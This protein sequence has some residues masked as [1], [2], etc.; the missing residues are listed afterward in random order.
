MRLNSYRLDATRNRQRLARGLGWFSVGLGLAELLMPRTMCRVIGVRPHKGLMRLLGLRE[1]ASGIGIL[2]QRNTASWLQSRV[3]GDVMDLALLGNAF[4]SKHSHAGRL[5]FATAAVSG[6]TALDALCAK[7]FSDRAGMQP[8]QPDQSGVVQFRRSI[9][10]NRSPEELYGL[11]HDF[12]QLPRF[13]HHV[14]S[15]HSGGDGRWHW[16]VAGPGGLRM[17]WDAEVTEDRPNEFIAWRSLPNADLDHAGSV[18]FERARGNRGTIIRLEL[19]YRPPAGKAGALMAKVLGQS[20]EKQ[21]AADLLR[22]KQVAETGEV[23]RTEGQPAGRERST[24]KKYD[25]LVRA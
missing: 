19:M 9:V 20:P 21:I 8:P 4:G 11:W 16:V 25:D 5:S 18:R 14:L 1:L 10:V 12:E 22:F 17:E 24:S 15:V 7:E 3:A 2:K 13:M 6:V 23:A